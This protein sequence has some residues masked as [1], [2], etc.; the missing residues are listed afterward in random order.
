MHELAHAAVECGRQAGA[1]VLESYPT[2]PPPEKTV[3]WDEASVGLLQV[4]QDAG[5]EV[6]AS[7]TRAAGWYVTTSAPPR[8]PANGRS[9]GPG[10]AGLRVRGVAGP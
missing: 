9:R 2:E 3:I 5:Y 6:V 1:H 4:F 8:R 7:P 10:S